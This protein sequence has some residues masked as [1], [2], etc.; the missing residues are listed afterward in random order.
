MK[1]SA[2]RSFRR[3]PVV[4]TA[5]LL[6]AAAVAAGGAPPARAATT[7]WWTTAASADYAGAETH[8]LV[9]DPDGVITLGPAAESFPVD[10][11]EVV[12]SAAV[13]ADGRVALGGDGG[14]IVR[15][16]R[17]R[18]AA[19]W[20]TLPVGQ[21][22]SLL[23]DGDDLIAGTGPD[24]L[25]Y[26][27]RANGDTAMIAA[28]GE[29]YVWALAPAGR[30]GWFAGTGPHGRVLRIGRDGKRR[31]LLD[32]D[33]QNIVSLIADGKGGAIAGGDTHG[34]VIAL[35]A[36]GAARTLYDAEEDEI[37][38]LA[39]GPDGAVYAAALSAK[40]VENAGDDD[41]APP[42]PTRRPASHEG[43]HV[44]RI[45]PDSLAALWWTAPDPIV[46]ALAGTRDGVVAATGH[47]AGLFVI[48]GAGRASRWLSPPEAQ[49][50][51]LA[52]DGAGTLYA[53]TSNPARLWEVRPGAGRSGEL[54]APV[55]DAQRIARFGRIRWFGRS[56]GARIELDTRSG[57]A[58]EPDTTWSPWSGG[59]AT[60][61]G[62]MV[63]AP[64]ARYLQWRLRLTGGDPR[65]ESVEVSWRENNV[66]PEV[67]GV[68]IAA[69]A[70]GFREGRLS[71]RT[72]PVTQELP[73][74]RRVEF[75][76]KRRSD[77][78]DLQALPL[79]AQGLR[80]V[81]WSAADPNDDP[82][83]YRI[84][85]AREGDDTW[86]P[87]T[88]DLGDSVYVWDTHSV[89]DGRYRLRVTASDVAGNAVG[90]EREGFAV[91][92]VFTV[93]NTPPEFT[94]LEVTGGAGRILVKGAASDANPV[95]RIEVAVD[96]DD[97][98]AVTPARGLDD[99]ARPAFEA[100]LRSVA[101]GAHAV[102]VRIVDR[103]GNFAVRAAR[104]TV[105]R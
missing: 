34:R 78:A 7:Q 58:A 90:E 72:E 51:A 88:R 22:L 95:A 11:L 47:R 68:R 26:R 37:R 71:P 93:D 42:R 66:P 12:W 64:P 39:L 19:P 52:R 30:A 15:W 75:S 101:P 10:S 29:R 2:A 31:V 99:D 16:S 54:L 17:G 67:A 86:L 65:I 35:T 84:D 3:A 20:V 40:A 102:T 28:T 85:V 105:T 27:I 4:R 73:G 43:A 59:A 49:V 61:A 80:S 91:G 100:T 21:V 62:R 14:R 76:L 79:W 74:G 77:E 36:D 1:R 89:P 41:D 98:R 104:A 94:S 63:E 92:P 8:G 55:L 13:L 53:A 6:L 24:G 18:G 83:T 33:E 56:G 70:E 46:F 81:Q 60:D 82:L 25:V 23:A 69:P 38:G 96:Q 57:N 103:A 48:Q 44:Y 97:W 87:V 50:T 45:V 32:T 5:V 9:V